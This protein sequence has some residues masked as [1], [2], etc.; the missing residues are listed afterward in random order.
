MY[1]D[2]R[3]IAKI[4]QVL[5]KI[6][7]SVM[8][9]DSGGTVIFPDG[10]DR[11]FNLPEAL[12]KNPTTPLVYGGFTLI[13]T[14]EKQPLFLTLPGDSTD[15]VNCAIL[16]AELVGMITKAD[17]PHADKV[18]TYRY[19]LREEVE[20]AEMEALALEH[21]IPLECKRCILLLHLQYVDAD[22]AIEIL[23]NVIDEDTDDAI[24]EVDRH[25]IVMIRNIDEGSEAELEDV[26]QLAQAIESTFASETSNPVYI[27]IGRP[28]DNLKALADSFREARRAV[29]VGRM[30]SKANRVF[31]YDR[32]LL[33]R[34]LADVPRDMARR[35]YEK[36][37][38]RETLRLFNDEM[39]STI[40][41]FFEN[42]LNL[43]ETARQLYIHRNTLVYRLD[44]IQRITGLDLRAF[45]D[46]VTFKLM[47]LLGRV[48]HEK[49]GRR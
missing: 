49:Q 16:A 15:V 4:E 8:L 34:F 45:D 9:L 23:E 44:K 13:G 14:D 20:G 7:S 42:S 35:Y 33:E 39:I 40:E 10:N 22:M 36:M 6:D 32:L 46:A 47:M 28:K 17:M 29:D 43:S 48:G 25:T 5:S 26:E 2:H 11:V 24:V 30:F 18:Q 12:R 31:S 1:I 3:V 27:G 37:F 41:K 38:N 21:N 19:I